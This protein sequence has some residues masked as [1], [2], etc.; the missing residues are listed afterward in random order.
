MTVIRPYLED[1]IVGEE[2]DWSA[3]LMDSSKDLIL[4]ITGL[5]NEVRRFMRAAH[6]GE[7]SLR[8]KG[9]D[10]STQLM[11]RL[12]HQAIFAAVG[13]S[14]AA[15][16]VILEGR[17]EDHRAVW[18]WWTA[19]IAGAMLAWSWWSSRNLLRKR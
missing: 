11:Y 13:I 12:G 4:S 5:P 2:G 19:R 6:A 10:Q 3:L 16:A 14:G 7:L 1:F 17:N 8:F 15:I 9:L 18:G